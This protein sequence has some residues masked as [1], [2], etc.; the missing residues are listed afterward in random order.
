MTAVVA[1]A[2]RTGT[3]RRNPYVGPRSFHAGEAL[4]GRTQEISDLRDLL[5]AQRIVLLYSPSGAGKTSLLEAGLRTELARRDFRVLPTVRVSHEVSGPAGSNRYLLSTLVSLEEG[6]P[7]HLRLS[8]AEL[9]EADLASYL[10]RWTADDDL[11]PCLFFDQFEELFTL[12]PTDVDAKAAFLTDLGVALRDRRRWALIAMREDFIA[13]LDPYLGL[14]P[15]RLASRYRLDL[16]GVDAA[17]AAARLPAAELGVDFTPAA[18]HRLVDDLRAVRVQRGTTVSDELGPY[19]EPVQL[20]VVCRR[21][22]ASL[23]ADAVAIQPE[24]VE[25]IGNVD[26]ALAD[27]YDDQVRSASGV[28]GVSEREIRA[29]VDEALLTEQGFRTEVSDGPRTNSAGVLRALEDGHLIRAERRRGTQWYELAHDRLVPPIQTSNAAWRQANL[30]TLQ[31]EAQTWDQRSR[32]AGLLMTGE[33]LLAATAWADAHPDELLAVDRDYLQ[34]CQAEERRAERER[35]AARRNRRLAIL[36]SIIGVVAVLGLIAAL[37]AYRQTAQSKREAARA[38]D[39]EAEAAAG[40]E[41]ATERQLAQASSG[42]WFSISSDP[43]VG[44]AATLYAYETHASASNEPAPVPILRALA[45]TRHHLLHDPITDSTAAAIDRTGQ[46]LVRGTEDGRVELVD[47]A[48]LART[49]LADLDAAISAVSASASD[50]RV[51]V[52]TRDEFGSTTLS[53]WDMGTRTRLIDLDTTGTGVVRSLAVAGTPGVVAAIAQDEAQSDVDRLVVWD[54]ETGDR[55][56]LPEGDGRHLGQLALSPDGS[57]LAATNDQ[58]MLPDSGPGLHVWQRDGAGWIDITPPWQDEAGGEGLPG[59]ALEGGLALDDLGDLLTYGSIELGMVAVAAVATGVGERLDVLGDVPVVDV[60][61]LPDGQLRALDETGSVATVGRPPEG[62]WTTRDTI[63]VPA[64]RSGAL[65]GGGS[66]VLSTETSTSVFDAATGEVLVDAKAASAGA[67]SADRDLVIRN[68]GAHERGAAVPGW[69]RMSERGVVLGGALS[70]DGTATALLGYDAKLRVQ[71]GSEMPELVDI[72]CPEMATPTLV[73][74]GE[75]ILDVPAV[76]DGAT[77]IGVLQGDAVCLWSPAGGAPLPVRGVAGAKARAVAIDGAGTIG[78]VGRDVNLSRSAVVELYDL[79][80]SQRL[81]TTDL[82]GSVTAVAA[83]LPGFE[84]SDSYVYAAGDDRG[85]VVFVEAM[86]PVGESGGVQYFPVTTEVQ[87]PVEAPVV[88]L[89]MVSIDTGSLLAVA[90]PTAVYVYAF[91]GEE[92]ALVG[93][94]D[95][96]RGEG[97]VLDLGFRGGDPMRLAVVGSDQSVYE[98]D[99]RADPQQVAAEVRAVATE[100]D[101]LL[102]DAQCQELVA[103][104]CPTGA[105]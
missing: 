85:N 57:R 64:R 22:W 16:L 35:I 5:I 96:E 15:K 14:I 39:R 73:V 65:A 17:T 69:T 77:Q 25:A 70:P 87:L 105:G 2:V 50:D 53:V 54:A 32:P 81:A 75:E 48:S 72:A 68:D 90:T 44:T 34:A 10:G 45:T 71:T 95:L 37:L 49:P 43:E 104:R 6:R 63:T 19:V 56:P 24:A 80:A 88:A 82:P 33:V 86:K 7:A 92:Q 1:D 18:A 67:T 55:L 13:Q 20:Q 8:D 76:A 23:D 79:M 66:R 9:A 47:L 97:T 40:R 29:W 78:V 91:E 31:R 84:G 83:G 36:T 21:L 4:Y 42:Q 51:V 27:F 11:D 26:D 93:G 58:L 28:A 52:Q 3:G 100:R 99:P 30:S 60:A 41:A 59:H 12:D 94:Y 61:F 101:L 103:Q 46:T 74:F 38:A 89:D 102:D 62:D 98:F